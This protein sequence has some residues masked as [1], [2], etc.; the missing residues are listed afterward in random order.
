MIIIGT[1]LYVEQLCRLFL[2]DELLKFIEDSVIIN[3]NEDYKESADHLI[4][5]HI[6]NSSPG[7]R[8]EKQQNNAGLVFKEIQLLNQIFVRVIKPWTSDPWS[9]WRHPFDSAIIIHDIVLIHPMAN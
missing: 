4:W 3:Y 7:R 1:F 5:S 9:R 2:M 6:K 8:T